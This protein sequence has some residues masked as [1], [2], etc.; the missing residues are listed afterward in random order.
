MNGWK[1]SALNTG[2]ATAMNKASAAILISDQDGV[3][4][5]ALAGSGDQQAGDD[6]DDEDRRQVE[7][8]AELRPWI[9]ASGKPRPTDLRNPAA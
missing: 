6:P 7:D 4:R 5:R 3:E 9:S 8:A 2:S 1:W